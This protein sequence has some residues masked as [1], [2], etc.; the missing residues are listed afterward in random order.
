M[1]AMRNGIGLA[2][3]DLVIAFDTSDQGTRCL[4]KVGAW[5]VDAGSQVAVCGPSGSGKTSLLNTLIALASP[6]LGRIVWGAVDVTKLTAAAADRWRRSTVGIVFQ[7]FHLLDGLS[8][9][10]NVLVATHFDRWR[11]PTAIATRAR[12]LLCQVGIDPK[13]DVMRL[14]RGEMQ[15]V[16][17]VR[18]LVH[19]PAIVVADEPTASLDR[20]MGASVSTLLCELSAASGATLIIA[21]HDEALAERLPQRVDIANNGLAHRPAATA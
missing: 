2:I 1:T 20:A 10:D 3:S 12:E 16:S 13:R 19:Q 21:T 18:A 17:I 4:L 7:H 5:Q 6:T 8:A 14:S 15:R 9:F 11:V